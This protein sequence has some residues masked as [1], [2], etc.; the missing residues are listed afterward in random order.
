M[1]RQVRVSRASSSISASADADRHGWAEPPSGEG[2]AGEEHLMP[3]ALVLIE[4]G[5]L[6][7]G[8]RPLPAHYDAGADGIAV[9]VDHAGQVG[10]RPR[11]A[12]TVLVQGRM[13]E[14]VRHGPDS[15]SDRLGDGVSDREEGTDPSLA[16]VADV[17][18]EGSC[19][20]GAV[21]AD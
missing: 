13:P 14:T 21:G 18:E 20:S 17:S 11:H 9:Q 8:M 12:P 15:A 16:Q 4:Q 1:S 2:S 7:S 19:R 6:G 10:D 3:H 5:Q